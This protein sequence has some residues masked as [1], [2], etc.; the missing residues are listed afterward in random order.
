[1]SKSKW[2]TCLYIIPNWG[3]GITGFSLLLKCKPVMNWAQ[4]LWFQMP[5]ELWFHACSNRAFYRP[6][7]FLRMPVGCTSGQCRYPPPPA[8][9]HI[10]VPSWASV[11]GNET[12]N[13]LVQC[14]L[15]I[16]GNCGSVQLVNT[17]ATQPNSH[18]FLQGTR[19]EQEV[20]DWPRHGRN[21]RRDQ[22]REQGK[23][24]LSSVGAARNSSQYWGE[25][26]SSG[27]CGPSLSPAGAASGHRRAASG[28][29]RGSLRSLG[30]VRAG[31]W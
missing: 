28:H 10:L 6:Q 20:R 30:P 27:R 15:Q 31:L 18:F 21:C 5:A 16:H 9:T 7:P 17:Q 26:S 2:C 14:G 13:G 29:R 11:I 12:M 25:A 3:A 8:H 23:W 4:I 24:Q 19:R 1:M 22:R